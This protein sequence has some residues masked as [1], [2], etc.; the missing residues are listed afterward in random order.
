[1]NVNTGI[2][3]VNLGTPCAA[4]V[5]SVKRYLNE[6]LTDPKVIDIPNP[7]R[8]LLVKGLIVPTRVKKSAHAYQQIW[9]PE[10]SPLMVHSVALK[11]ALQDL[12]G[13]DYVVSLGMNYGEPS[14]AG[15]LDELKLCNKIIVLPLFPQYSSAVTES[16]L[17]KIKSLTNRRLDIIKDFY[18][19]ESYIQAMATKVQATLDEFKPEYLLLSYHGLP[20]R[21]L[22]KTSGDVCKS[23]IVEPC[24]AINSQNRYCY[25]AQCYET[26]HLITQKLSLNKTKTLTSFQSRLGRLTWTQPY[27]EKILQDLAAQGVKRIAVSCPSFITDC[28]ETLEEIGLRAQKT[29]VDAGGEALRLIPALNADAHWLIKLDG[30]IG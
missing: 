28:L 23:C 9:M 30:F 17:D 24:P 21:Q 26:S 8:S 10:G 20:M 25:R 15:A 13:S 1:M 16:I 4:D 6:F 3:L 27:T 5:A 29:W 14:I 11:A 12:L 2:L 22:Y 18:N 19:Q 7:W